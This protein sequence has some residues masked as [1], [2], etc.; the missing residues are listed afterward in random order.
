MGVFRFVHDS[1][2]FS[3]SNTPTLMGFR[4]VLSLALFFGACSATRPALKAPDAGRRT[5][6]A[7]QPASESRADAIGGYLL[8]A[9]P[10]RFDHLLAASEP[11]PAKPGSTSDDELR[12]QAQNP[13]ASLISLPLQNNTNFTVG[14][15]DGVQNV[16]NIQPVWPFKIGDKWNLITRTILPVVYQPSPAAGVSSD[17]GLGDTSF[18][19]FFSPI[20][21]SKVT[22][23]VGPVILIPTSTGRTLGAGEWG[24]G[25]SAVVVWSEKPWVA[26]AI[27]NNVWSFG[28]RVNSLLFQYFVNYNLVNGWYL[29][30]AP[31]I[32]ADWNATSGNR[33]TIPFGAGVGRLM[34]FGK[35]P[36]NISLQ[37][38][39]NVDRPNGGPEWQIRFQ[40]QFLF[41]K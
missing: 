1:P 15:N 34:K 36:V 28:G 40:I 24:L 13:V 32:T 19:A 2:P 27:I 3:L 30:T 29:V 16:L 21:K 11:E 26:G 41:P 33:W 4:N 23:G 17:F 8:A 22:W 12:R 7:A 38:Y 5:T 39:Y 14:P 37:L 31:I 25:P 18:T 9:E 10:E 6:A 35:Q 20:G